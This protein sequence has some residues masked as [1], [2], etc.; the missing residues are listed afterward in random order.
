MTDNFNTRLNNLRN[1]LVNTINQS[2]VPA[3]AIFYLLKDLIAE[4]SDSYKQSV[5]MEKQISQ[6][7][8]ENESDDVDDGHQE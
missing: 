1:D 2:G 3:G 8:K 7:V 6:L 5:I 4:T